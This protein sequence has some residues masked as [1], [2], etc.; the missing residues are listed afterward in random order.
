MDAL[1][2]AVHPVLQLSRDL[3]RLGCHVHLSDMNVSYLKPVI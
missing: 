3:L 1:L 2:C